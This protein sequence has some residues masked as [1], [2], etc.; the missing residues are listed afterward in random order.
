MKER[1]EAIPGSGLPA[2]ALIVLLSASIGLF[3]V[4]NGLLWKAP[5]E[6]SHLARF[7]V[8][9]LAVI[10]LGAG[11]LWAL[12]RF[13]WMHLVTTTCAV[14]AIKLVVTAA[15][16]QA[17]ARGTATELLAVAPPATPTVAAP[18]TDYRAAASF[19]ASAITGH[20]RLRGVA[21]GGAVVLLDGPLPG[22][23][24]PPPQKVESRG[25]GLS[26]REAAVSGARRRRGEPLEP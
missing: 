3:M 7:T 24:A 22:R 11:L 1:P 8:S 6:A 15:L 12:R 9:Y 23:A 17:F 5:R 21:L 26:L 10:P 20:V 16:Y 2:A 14:W 19:A 4:W 18:R 13:S 25:L